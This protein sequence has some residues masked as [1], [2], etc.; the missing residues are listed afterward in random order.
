MG[1]VVV[2]FVKEPCEAYASFSW[3]CIIVYVYL[4]VFNGTP[5]PLCE[6]IVHGPATTIH[7][8]FYLV[9]Q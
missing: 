5:E 9:F 1:P 3:A 6:Y 2:V 8:Y 7:A 4:L